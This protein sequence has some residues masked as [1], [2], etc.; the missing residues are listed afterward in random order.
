M[1]R[2]ATFGQTLV[3]QYL[4]CDM[5]FVVDPLKSSEER[6]RRIGHGSEDCVGGHGEA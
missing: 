3:L 2:V 4:V 1:V 6:R 5:Y